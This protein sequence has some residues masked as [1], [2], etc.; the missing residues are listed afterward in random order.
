MAFHVCF[1]HLISMTV[2]IVSNA[3]FISIKICEIGKFCD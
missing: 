1:M 3:V 2:L